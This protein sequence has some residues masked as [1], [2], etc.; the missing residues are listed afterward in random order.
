MLKFP[1][2]GLIVS[3]YLESMSGSEKEFISA[4][5]HAPGVV[6]LRVEGLE[7]IAH[8]RL[9]APHKFIIGLIKEFDGFRNLIDGERERGT[10]VDDD[11]V[12]VGLVIGDQ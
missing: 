6:G 9:I 11:T 12:L 10:M 2:N 4:V 3:C 8:A 5:A 7:N 1:E